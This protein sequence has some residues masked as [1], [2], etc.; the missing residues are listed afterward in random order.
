[1][2]IDLNHCP[3]I[4]ALQVEKENSEFD[5]GMRFSQE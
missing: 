2:K 3:S 5:T 4:K 1:M